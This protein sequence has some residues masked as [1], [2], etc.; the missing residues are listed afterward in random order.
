MDLLLKGRLP[1]VR[2]SV[3]VVRSTLPQCNYS[4][5]VII[6]D[7]DGSL[8]SQAQVSGFLVSYFALLYSEAGFL[9]VQLR[10]SGAWAK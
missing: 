3:S 7:I 1:T 4:V 2:V 10:V 9:K 6:V 8:K 5:I